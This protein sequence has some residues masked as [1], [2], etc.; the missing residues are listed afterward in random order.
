MLCFPPSRCNG[1]LKWPVDFQLVLFQC[2]AFQPSPV[3]TDVNVF[4]INDR[5]FSRDLN[6]VCNHICCCFYKTSYIETRWIFTLCARVVRDFERPSRTRVSTKHVCVCPVV[7]AG[8]H[9]TQNMRVCIFVCVWSL[10]R[11]TIWLNPSAMYDWWHTHTLNNPPR[12]VTE[13]MSTRRARRNLITLAREVLCV[14][15][16]CISS[17][18]YCDQGVTGY[19]H[20]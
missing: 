20:N 11:K 7:C 15:W 3:W 17:P 6:V 12:H 9:L 10:W 19:G 5:V 1:D 8:F 16:I 4:V 2:A 13:L 14:V 18:Q